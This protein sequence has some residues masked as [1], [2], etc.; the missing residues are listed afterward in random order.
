MVGCAAEAMS[1]IVVD[2]GGRQSGKTTRALIW[3]LG[4]PSKRVVVVPNFATRGYLKSL[5]VK[6]GHAPEAVTVW[7]WHDYLVGGRA[8]SVKCEFWID[9][10]GMCLPGTVVGVSGL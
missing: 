5:L 4:D 6:M 3:A 10:I 7:T 8:A 2:Y 1:A 9:E